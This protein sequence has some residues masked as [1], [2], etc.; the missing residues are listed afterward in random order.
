[1]KIDVRYQKILKGIAIVGM[2]MLHFWGN[3]QWITPNNMYE[4]FFPDYFYETIGRFGNVC[5][6][7]FAF[8]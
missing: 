1:M 4:G 2:M 5:V 7:I 8:L 6:S 3:P